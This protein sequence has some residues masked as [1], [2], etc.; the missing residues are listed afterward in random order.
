MHRNEASTVNAVQVSTA[1]KPG[2]I[3]VQT[4]ANPHNA[5]L[6]GTR[7]ASAKTAHH[8]DT[9]RPFAP[10]LFVAE[11]SSRHPALLFRVPHLRIG[12]VGSCGAFAKNAGRFLFTSCQ[13]SQA[14][15]A[16]QA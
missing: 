13:A 6:P 3:P 11:A 15:Q 12:K 7:R 9:L 8:C 2:A 14:S 5:V 4:Y 16:S 1:A 10:W